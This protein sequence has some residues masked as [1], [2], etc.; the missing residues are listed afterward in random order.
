MPTPELLEPLA[1]SFR[2]SD[3]DFGQLVETM[4]RSNLFF[5]PEVYRTKVKSPVDFALG[6]VHGLE[7]R[8]GT[9]ALSLTLEELG[10]NV[11]S[12]RP[13]SRAGTAARP[14]STGRRCSIGRTWPW[15]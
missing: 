9:T 2:D 10:Q 5:A 14:G 11:C 13:R 7:G 1:T 3:Y 15:P 6:I 8:I 12:I 4:L